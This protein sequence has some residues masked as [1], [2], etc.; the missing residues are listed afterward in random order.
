[1]LYFVL[2]DGTIYALNFALKYER[3]IPTNADGQVFGFSNVRDE[4][5][6]HSGNDLYIYNCDQPVH[7]T[8]FSS[9]HI[10]QGCLT[11]ISG[12]GSEGAY[13]GVLCPNK[14]VKNLEIYSVAC[15]NADSSSSLDSEC[16][17]LSNIEI[18][19][20]MPKEITDVMAHGKY[21]IIAQNEFSSTEV[22]IPLT[23]ILDGELIW[24]K[25]QY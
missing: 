10:N 15:P 23:F 18:K 25:S 11:S 3:I 14:N 5:F 22:D 2:N 1:M 17:L 4:L 13:I 19:I 7:N 12:T 8:L 9:V 24:F 21:S 20:G 16:V 6:I